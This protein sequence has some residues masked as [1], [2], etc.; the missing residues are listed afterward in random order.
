MKSQ[1]QLEE[2]ARLT[3]AAHQIDP[4]LFCALIEQES[5]WYE[6]ALRFEP[7]F[8]E[9]YTRP[10]TL[11]DTEEHARAFSWGLCQVMGQTAREFGF[12]GRSLAE[13]TDPYVNL[14]LGVRILKAKL[15]MS[16]T[17]EAALNRYNGGANPEYPQLVLRHMDKFK[18]KTQTA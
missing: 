6:H 1:Q 2:L 7:R 8:Y 10:M 13:L 5:S 3:A 4:V 9:K 18:A 11:S 15:S 14:D 12:K 17:V 16:A